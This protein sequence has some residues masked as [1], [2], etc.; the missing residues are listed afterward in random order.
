MAAQPPAGYIFKGVS[1]SPTEAIS[2]NSH[3]G[4]KTISKSALQ[5]YIDSVFNQQGVNRA[6]LNTVSKRGLSYF[7]DKTMPLSDMNDPARKHIQLARMYNEIKESLPSILIVDAGMQFVPNSIGSI[8][9]ASL[10]NGKWQGYYHSIARVPV[11]VSIVTGDQETTDLLQ[12]I[13]V[14]MFGPLR[15]EAGGSRITS[16]V[17]GE[18]WEV[19]LPL[20]FTPG[21]NTGTNIDSDP[22]DQVWAT[23]IDLELTFEDT[24][25]IERDINAPGSITGTVGQPDVP[26]TITVESSF[27]INSRGT[28]VINGLRPS[29]K[30]YIDK[31]DIAILDTKTGM[32]TP[33]R[34]GTFNLVVVDLA[35]RENQTPVA[36]PPKV[37]ASKQVTITL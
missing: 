23:T 14:T 4:I 6:L 2:K 21:V 33:R 31:P 15:N 25:G 7:T 16:K 9:N 20:T 1:K 32:I 29:Y 34:L 12:S 30:V 19:R 37:V 27:S 18:T 36:M 24:I 17:P 10:H 8:F 11:V 22:K 3:D 28:A 35:T 13:L 26:V 5:G